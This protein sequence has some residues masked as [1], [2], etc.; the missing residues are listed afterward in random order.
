MQPNGNDG[1]NYPSK[2]GMYRATFAV[3]T[4]C[5]FSYKNNILYHIY[6]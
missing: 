1:L 2:V 4:N 5:K 6:E 3:D